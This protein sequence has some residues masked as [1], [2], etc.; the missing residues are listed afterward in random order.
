MKH[1]NFSKFSLL[2]I[3]AMFCFTGCMNGPEKT[4]DKAMKCLV[5]ED[6]RGLMD[7]FYLSD[8]QKDQYA[9]LYEKSVAPDLRKKRGIKKYKIAGS[10]IDKETQKAIV[11]VH[12]TYGDNSEE[13]MNF[14]LINVN[15]KWLQEMK[16]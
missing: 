10:D 16:K 3:V 14:D 15:G 11:T 13:D 12:V 6:I 5:K 7:T 8:R 2:F 9:E 4:A 1:F